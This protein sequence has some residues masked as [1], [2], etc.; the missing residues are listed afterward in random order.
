MS[1]EEFKEL[2][3]IKG[4]SRGLVLKPSLEF[5]LEKEG[6]ESLKKVEK[7]ITDLGYPLK[8]NKINGMNFYPAGLK[9]VVLVIMKRLFNY[10]DNR[11]QELG[12]FSAKLPLL[13][14]VFFRTF[15]TFKKMERNV[16]KMWR[17]FFTFGDLKMKEL[18]REKGYLILRL[19]NFNFHPLECQPLV[20]IFSTFYKIMIN[21]EITC[22]E[23]KCIYRGDEYHE[24]LIK[25]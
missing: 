5:I 13:I 12:K 22:E 14:R 23:T 9:A 8:H 18:N 25:W 24:F 20:G 21:K 3:N 1:K 15:L 7:I 2:M 6:K 10:D 16:E 4:L 17:A 19:E 11:F